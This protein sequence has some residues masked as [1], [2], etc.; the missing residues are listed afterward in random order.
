METDYRIGLGTGTPSFTLLCG[1][2]DS[3]HYQLTG[4]LEFGVMMPFYHFGRYHSSV[5]PVPEEQEKQHTVDNI[6]PYWVK[7]IEK[8]LGSI[9]LGFF[10]FL[11]EK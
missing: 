10:F 4:P 9:G 7:T 6:V 3:S 2:E 11:N 5:D 1:F 8:L